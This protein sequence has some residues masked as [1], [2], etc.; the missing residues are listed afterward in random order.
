[1]TP[2]RGL[3]LDE[4]DSVVDG[5][6]GL[7]GQPTTIMEAYEPASLTQDCILW[8]E[9][10]HN[11]DLRKLADPSFQT[12]SGWDAETSP[13]SDENHKSNRQQQQQQQRRNSLEDVTTRHFVR[14]NNNACIHTF[15]SSKGETTPPVNRFAGA[16][17]R[18]RHRQQH[19]L[20]QQQQQQNQKHPFLRT[21]QTETSPI[22]NSSGHTTEF[23]ALF[24]AIQFS[25]A[26][27]QTSTN[28]ILPSKNNIETQKPNNPNT[29]QWE[30]KSM[31]PPPPPQ[32]HDP[33][34]TRALSTTNQQGHHGSPDRTAWND[35]GI[36]TTK[37]PGA[38][39]Q[40]QTRIPKVAPKH[41]HPSSTFDPPTDPI[42]PHYEPTTNAAM[43]A[44]YMTTTNTTAATVTNSIAEND[45]PFGDFPDDFDFDALDRVVESNKNRMPISSAVVVANGSE[46]E[47]AEKAPP[48]TIQPE[49]DDPFGDIFTDLDFDAM[50]KAVQ[51]RTAAQYSIPSVQA[52]VRNPRRK[53][54]EQDVAFLTFSRY[55]VL[56]VNDD[57]H[58]FTKTLTVSRWVV[59]MLEEAENVSK[60]LHQHSDVSGRLRECVS[61][62]TWP[63]SGVI[64]LRGEW[65]HTRV[66]E[67]D[68]I[69]VCSLAG[70]F[71]TDEGALPLLL[72]TCPPPGSDSDDLVLIVHPDMLLT[73]TVISETIGCTRR[74]VLKTRLGSTGLRSKSALFGTMRHDLFEE[75]M[76]NQEFSMQSMSLYI[77]NIVKR[78]AEGLV[79]CGIS[80]DEAENE[81]RK[82]VPQLQHFANKYTEFGQI[83]GVRDISQSTALESQGSDPQTQFIAKMAEAV[84]EPIISPELG[85]KGNIDMI[86]R[87]ETANFGLEQQGS[88]LSFMSLEL[89]T[90]HNQQPQ[91]AHIAQLVFYILMMQT[92]HGKKRSVS[93]SPLHLAAAES[94]LL[95]YM[96]NDAVKA[97]HIVPHI[98]EIKSLIGQ[99]NVIA[100]EQFRATRPRGIELK[101][102]EDEGS[103][104]P[105][106]R[107]S[108]VD[109]PPPAQL[110]ELL[111]N[112][113]LCKNCYVNRE[114]ILYAAA[115]R[116]SLNIDGKDPT[117][118]DL[119]KQF[120][121]HL[122]DEEYSYF[123]K[124][125]R[126]IDIEADSVSSSVASAW[127]I[128]SEIRETNTT[129]SIS[130]LSHDPS[131]SSQ[132][133]ILDESWYAILGFRRNSAAS[134]HTPL[135]NVGFGPG[136]QVIVSTD[137]TTLDEIESS[138]TKVFRAHM[139]I[140]RGVIHATTS[141]TLQIRASRDD[142][143]RIQKITKRL[144]ASTL[145]RCDRDD[146]AMGIGTLRQNLINF[147]TLD[148]NVSE[149]TDSTVPSERLS[150]LRD[151]IIRRK[152][153]VHDV[154]MLKF[155]F[156]P[157]KDAL[158]FR[159][160]GCDLMDLVFEHAELNPDQRAAAETVMIAKDYSLIHGLPGTGKTSVIAF[161]I[162][163]LVAHGKRVL[164]TS[165]THSAV[166]NVLL[167]LM[168][169]GVASTD[170]NT[171]VPALIRIGNKSSCHPSVHS[172]LVD[173][174]ASSLE[175]NSNDP[176]V[177][178]KPSAE[179]LRRAMNSAR[180]VGVTALTVPRSPLLFKERFDVVIVDEAGQISQPAVI[181][182]LMAA[183]T[184]VLV[185]DHMQLPP[186]VVS[187]LAGMGGELLNGN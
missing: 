59:D 148:A 165:Y 39:S 1:M 66:H 99:R 32:I 24:N 29:K 116:S 153:P 45:D 82:V 136:S 101:Y 34:P 160:P 145:F 106:A 54:V 123:M 107:V 31:P 161:I 2:G 109:P 40:V 114:C 100:T 186:L 173:S 147:L 7:D 133:A 176:H 73:P 22:P 81:L 131:I 18:K 80:S 85:L 36:R 55:K 111:P 3:D 167:K 110:P 17:V 146:N 126:L 125:D 27:L 156:S 102:D 70:D 25:P 49:E 61:Q 93:T 108:L 76:R 5:L 162:R 185:G 128:G 33:Q 4:N 137:S 179:S 163:L 183:D 122:T 91:I 94:G 63:V 143:V 184:F 60:A 129:N 171:P 150:W 154:S 117:H 120:A 35:S 12:P 178:V 23:D 38:I 84:E 140:V 180:I 79:C 77:A 21:V 174:V 86:V 175:T 121:G 28:R 90:G 41:F 158:N 14:N 46:T 119:M 51:I 104:R 75:T 58:T 87:A 69:H 124:W 168:E 138:A 8:D 177:P 15:D 65:Y 83:R 170:A 135:T 57:Q 103:S 118:H 157:G 97:V 10:K 37:T 78:N 113:Y 42:I 149:D 130:S 142:L 56:R 47:E 172:L 132:D 67:G 44:P 155:M 48:P 159:T 9:T 13:H 74:A 187:E 152:K 134:I 92:R 16:G 151:V 19:V 182:A 96:N 115:N 144:G 166:D 68:T 89:K 62:K 139:H 30:E 20:L 95:L 64:H 72:H 71:R 11:I 88:T 169:K 43:H 6:D 141:D 98:S 53:I 105:K 52:P 50:D 26:I 112:S 164:I 181:G 127:L